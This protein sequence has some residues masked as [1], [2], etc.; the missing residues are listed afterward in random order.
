M[1]VP[2]GGDV[3]TGRKTARGD[4]EFRDLSPE[5]VRGNLDAL[6]SIA[7]DVAGEYWGEDHFLRDLPEKWS[8]SFGAW[9]GAHPVGYAILSRQATDRAHLHHFMIASSHR[10]HEYGT[11]MVGEMEDR[12]RRAGCERLSLKVSEGNDGAQRFY[13]RLGY[14]VART[15]GPYLVLERRLGLSNR[16]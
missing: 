6:L 14:R 15:D 1:T 10:G 11:E 2:N 16:Q 9:S 13:R 4:V 3:R 7:A 8:L 5:I 12:A